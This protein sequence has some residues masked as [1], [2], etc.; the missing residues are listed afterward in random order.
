MKEFSYF[1][2]PISN[3]VPVKKM[4]LAGCFEMIRE[5]RDLYDRTEAVKKILG[6]N[7]ALKEEKD[8]AFRKKKEQ[9][10]YITPAGVFAPKRG[11]EYLKE[12]SGYLSLDIDDVGHDQAV[13]L[14]DQIG[15]DDCLGERLTFVSPSGEGVKIIMEMYPWIDDGTGRNKYDASLTYDPAT[16]K[17]MYGE[18]WEIAVFYIESMYGCEADQS[19]KDIPRPLFLIHDKDAVY[20]ARSTNFT[21]SPL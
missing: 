10:P 9:L 1:P 17:R 15:R 16:L 19:C 21:F 20:A 12:L 11:E 7:F 18:A 8:A 14:R 6:G 3:T 2:G 4:T 13:E 5:D